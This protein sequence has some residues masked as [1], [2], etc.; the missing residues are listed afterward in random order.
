MKYAICNETFEGWDHERVCRFVAG[1]GYQGLELAPFTLAPRIT[2]VSAEQR[3]KLRAEAERHGVSI[4]GLHWLLAKTQGLQLTSPDAQ[5]RQRTAE[6][7]IELARCCRDLG[8]S[9]L[10]FGSPAQRRI[11]PG[12]TLD[13]AT[14][15][16]FDTLQQATPVLAD[17]NVTLALEP[18]APAE[19]DFLT[20]CEE[21]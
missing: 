7:L 9:I 12:Y 11:P 15:F 3:A 16:A 20:T 14:D 13:Q 2:D 6:Y 1:L 19:C 8:G 10:V 17:V 4:I 5:V 18:L 21:A